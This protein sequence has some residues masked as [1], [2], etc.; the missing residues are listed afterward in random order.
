MRD[1]AAEERIARRFAL[2]HV[3]IEMIARQLR[4]SL[5]V[6]DRDFALGGVERI[7][8][9][10]RIERLAKRMHA[11]IALRPAADPAARDG[12][13]DIRRALH[14]RALHVV[15]HAANAAHLLASAGAPGTAVHQVR[16]R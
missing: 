9:C 15:Q 13:D 7:A 12:S 14:G 10:E 16:E 11:R 2:V 1:A 3:R 8:D 5:D 6:L 4:E